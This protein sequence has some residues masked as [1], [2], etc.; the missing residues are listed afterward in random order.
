[1]KHHILLKTKIQAI[2]FQTT[3][4]ELGIAHATKKDNVRITI[5]EAEDIL[6]DR[7]ITY[8]EVLKVKFED[9]D[10]EI[11]LNEYENYII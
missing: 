8:K 2:Y 3:T 9:I 10:L 7:E 5:A 11:P 4:D 6:L 1:M